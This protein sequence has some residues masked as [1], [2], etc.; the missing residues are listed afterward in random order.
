MAVGSHFKISA[1]KIATAISNYLP[2]NNR[3]QIERG[4]NNLLILDAY[5]AN[6]DSMK[7]A[8]QFFG[9]QNAESKTLILGDMLELGDFEETK[10]R[11]ILELIIPLNFNHTFLIGKAFGGLKKEYSLFH[12]F[13]TSM[14]AKEHFDRFP[15]RDNHILLKGSRGIQ[16]EVL[17]ETLL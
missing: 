1:D 5:N 17:K 2:S 15:I 7:N 8:I 12:F 6:P 13:E 16:L 11:E 4:P 9:D 3:S 14:L 10:H